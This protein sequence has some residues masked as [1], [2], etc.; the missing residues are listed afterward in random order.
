MVALTRDGASLPVVQLEQPHSPGVTSS[1]SGAEVGGVTSLCI[2][3]DDGA[4][5]CAGE[6]DSGRS[7]GGSSGA[8]IAGGSS[9]RNSEE[10]A[11]GVAMEARWRDDVVLSAVVLEGEE[12]SV[13]GCLRNASVRQ[14]LLT[15]QG[16]S[17]TGPRP[18]P[19]D[20][21]QSFRVT[22]GD[23]AEESG[24]PFCEVVLEGEEKGA[25]D[26]TV[27]KETGAEEEGAGVEET[28]TKQGN[29]D[30]SLIGLSGAR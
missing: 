18:M 7:C 16:V 19:K 13:L 30:T 27:Q 24:I 11:V 6:S 15:V 20:R 5:T 2:V 28:E 8:A 25:R 1:I 9:S 10:G 12:D 14:E 17:E 23:T 29:L 21:W 22:A 4:P 26:A 3:S